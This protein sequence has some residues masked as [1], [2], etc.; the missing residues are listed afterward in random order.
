MFTWNPER[1]PNPAQL[2]DALHEAGF[3]VIS[4]VDPGVKVDAD[5]SVYTSG[6]A[7]DVYIRRADG[8]VFT[9]YVWPDESAFADFLHPTAQA[10]WREH[11]ATFLQAGIDGIWNDMN[12]P[13]VFEKPFS[14]GDSNIGTIDLDAMQGAEDERASHAEV[15]NLYANLMA[16]VTYQTLREQKGVRPFVLTRA[17][18]AGIQRWSATWTGDNSSLWEHL[19]LA[20]PQLLNLG[21]SGVPFVGVDIGGFGGNATPELFARWMQF[22]ILMPFCRAHT[23]T[24]TERHEPWAFGEETEAIVRQY[25]QLRYRWLPYLY[26]LFWEAHQHATPILRPLLYEFP[27]DEQTYAM[28]D[29]MMLGPYVMA[30][31]VYQ[32]GCETRQVYLPAGRWTDYWTDEI[33]MGPRTLT[34]KTPLA[35]MPLFVRA[36]ACLPSTQAVQTTR[37]Y[38]L[39]PLILDILS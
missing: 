30:A 10:W 25:L 36:G 35:H 14:E 16:E 20:M 34:V 29:Q 12:E 5:Y 3:R 7:Q 27:D 18:F 19:A 33:F 4:I 9:G 31:P 38:Q 17:G 15:H 28:S 37:D 24:G 6:L 32:A 26:T 23:E 22:G 13:T 2:M 11:L 39:N 8:S 1:F 21:L